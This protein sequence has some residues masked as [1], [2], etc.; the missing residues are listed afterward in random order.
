MTVTD[1]VTLVRIDVKMWV[2]S[3]GR[4][5]RMLGLPAVAKHGSFLAVFGL[6]RMTDFESWKTT[7][8][9]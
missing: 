3:D 5:L 6:W 1:S 9:V 4:M 8:H 2:S 7:G